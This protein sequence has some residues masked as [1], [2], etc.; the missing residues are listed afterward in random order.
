MLSIDPSGCAQNVLDVHGEAGAA[1]LAGLPALI[2]TAAGRWSLTILPPFPRLSYNY[3]TPAVGPVGES[4]VLKAGVPNWELASEI[5]ALRLFDGRGAVRLLEADREAGLLLLERAEPGDSLWAVED[6]AERVERLALVMGRL[7]Q[8]LAP[9]HP[10]VTLAELFARGFAKLRR[11]FEGE[12]GPFPARRIERA[13]ALARELTAA[14][15]DLLIHG[16]LNPGNVLSSERE[17]CL[18]ID[19]KGY[20]GQPLY[21]VATFLN[22]PPDGLSLDEL[23]RLQSHRVDLL[24]SALGVGRAD[25]LAWAEAHAVLAGWWSYEDHGEGWEPAFAL[26]GVYE[27]LAGS[28]LRRFFRASPLVG[29]DLDLSR[30]DSPPREP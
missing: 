4:L 16:D 27:T 2:A 30:D 19:P 10:F 14:G 28:S 26:A 24:A 15:G 12:T 9:G 22:D 20:A 3:V 8:P 29:I 23:R 13:E 5:D 1:W 6:D 7:W 11:L 25:I 21:D 18:A 17:G